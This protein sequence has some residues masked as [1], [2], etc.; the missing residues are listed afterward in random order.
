LPTSPLNEHHVVEFISEWVARRPAIQLT[1]DRFGNLRLRI[2]RGTARAH[3][4]LVFAAHMD[5]P[6]FE[7]RRMESPRR[8]Q[9]LWRGGVPAEYFRGAGVRFF[10]D[11]QW[12]RGVVRSIR[13]T[14]E[15]GRRRVQSAMIELNRPVCSGSVGMWDLPDPRIRGSRIY[16]RGCDDIAGL[17]AVLA[18][19]DELRR[20]SQ[21]LE[22]CALLTRAEEVGFA[23]AIAA[24]RSGLLPKRARVIA[25]EC[26]AEVPGVQMGDGPILRVGDRSSIFTPH[27]TAFCQR[28]AEDLAKCGR[29]FI[30]QRRL[31]DG[32]T[33]ESTVYC[34]SGFEATGL[35]IALGNYHNVN[36]RRRRIGP[37]YV[38]LNDFGRLITWLIALARSKRDCSRTDA[39]LRSSLARLDREWSPRLYRTADRI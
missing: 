8:L 23:G 38:D 7:S 17:A 36:A 2:R 16:A 24:C 30:C 3:R 29:R 14:T 37:E 5:H 19:L 35:C 15:R 10:S 12:V 4:P 25:I 13:L 32:G 20:G 27:L 22:V 26:S 31:M 33:C 39:E 21:P 11:G 1:S 9:A 28:V 18:A 34:T 6:G